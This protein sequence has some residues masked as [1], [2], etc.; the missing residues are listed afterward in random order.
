MSTMKQRR[1]NI[2]EHGKALIAA[3]EDHDRKLSAL[4]IA[5][6][7]GGDVTA[8]RQAYEAAQRIALALVQPKED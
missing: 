8:E 4:R 5:E 1:P 6:A 7:A 2:S 3:C